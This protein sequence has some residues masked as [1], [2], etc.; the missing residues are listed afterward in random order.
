MGVFE[1]FI[2]AE[3]PQRIV[4]IKG[5]TEATG[6]PNLS[7]LQKVNI[8]PNGTL[9][10]QEDVYPR[11]L[12]V[13]VGPNSDDWVLLGYT[14]NIPTS[15]LEYTVISGNSKIIDSI[16]STDVKTVKWIVDIR[17]TSKERSLEILALNKSTGIEFSV[18]NVLG[19]VIGVVIDVF[20]NVDDIVMELTN[21]ELEDVD[22][23]MVRTVL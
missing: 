11:A 18:S 5:L 19:D 16:S 2:Y 3:L 10:L 7:S 12:W 22:I 9:Y 4:L 14:V 15:K 23:T 20:I 17:H 6:D 13:K 1:D 21:N 8:A